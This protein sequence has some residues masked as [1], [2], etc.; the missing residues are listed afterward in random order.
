MD[1]A[2]IHPRH[3]NRKAEFTELV[4]SL[5]VVARIELQHYSIRDGVG[6]DTRK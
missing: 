5:C 2:D 3:S 4:D 1:S 6:Q